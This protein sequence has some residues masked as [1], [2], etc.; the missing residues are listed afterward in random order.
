MLG[1]RSK[2]RPPNAKTCTHESA[3]SGSERSSHSLRA[4]SA[5]DLSM[6]IVETGSSMGSVAKPKAPLGRWPPSAF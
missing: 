4:I 2:A 3:D 1:E 6:M 5:M